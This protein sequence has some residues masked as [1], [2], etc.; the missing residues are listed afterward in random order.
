[1][2]FKV[3]VGPAQIAIHHGRTVLVCEP[4]GQIHSP[5]DKGLY[6]NDTRLISSW[7]LYADGLPWSLLSGGAVTYDT[8]RVHMT[9]CALQTQTGPIA[10]RTLGLVLSRTIQGGMHEDIDITNHGP[11]T[12]AFQLEIGIRC[13]FADVFEAKSNTLVRRGQIDTTWSSAEQRLDTAYNNAEFHRSVTVQPMCAG[14]VRY[15]NGR[16]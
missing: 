4:D 10:A 1:M 14:A 11:T 13:D 9:N 7:S 2:S 6:F 15:A 5:S 3:Q 8:M 16:L 12:V